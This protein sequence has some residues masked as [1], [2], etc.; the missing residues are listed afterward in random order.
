MVRAKR[1][2]I[3]AQQA[4]DRK[5]EPAFE[6]ELVTPPGGALMN[7]SEMTANLTVKR[8]LSVQT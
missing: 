2:N 4:A 8:K 7:A 6:I 5:F 3:N 1:K